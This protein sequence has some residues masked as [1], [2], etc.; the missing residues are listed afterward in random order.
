M[1]FVVLLFIL[2]P[3]LNEFIRLLFRIEE[4]MS[5][6]DYLWTM[7]IDII[8]GNP[9]FGLGPGA[10]KYELF[11]YYPFMLNEFYGKVFIYYIEVAEGVNL[12]HNLILVFFTEMGI[13]GLITVLALPIIYFRIG[14]MT[15]KK[16]KSGPKDKYYSVIGLFAAGAS[17]IFRNLF[18]SIGLIYIGGV[19]SDLPFW[20]IL[21]SLVYYYQAPINTDNNTDEKV[22]F[23]VL[24]K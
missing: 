7:S 15:I 12:A 11:N 4:G 24:T 8:K 6:R 16:Y 9:I 19:H 23:P 18:N 3:P 17:I 13:L 10:Y 5:A 22:S 1:I 2:S 14:L 20:L 21:S